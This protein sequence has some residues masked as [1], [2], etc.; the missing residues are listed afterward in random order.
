MRYTAIYVCLQAAVLSTPP[1]LFGSMWI[2]R[3][4][5]HAETVRRQCSPAILVPE[6]VRVLE[7][8][9]PRAAVLL[10]PVAPSYVSRALR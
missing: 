1:V 3:L 8:L 5:K 2:V 6:D 4:P 9:G 10:A 7:V